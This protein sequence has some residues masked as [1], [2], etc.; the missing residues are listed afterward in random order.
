MPAD[1]PVTTATRRALPFDCAMNLSLDR[2]CGHP[3]DE[4]VDEERIKDR[5]WDRAEQRSGHQ[6]APIEDVTSHELRGDADGDR[7]ARGVADEHQRVDVLVPRE[8]EREEPSADDA[9]DRQRKDDPHHRL[10]A[11]G[12]VDERSLFK[13]ARDALE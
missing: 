8:R 1:A 9:G 2:A 3:A 10:Q 5:D 7:L 4:L 11:R 12:A 6:L 13:L